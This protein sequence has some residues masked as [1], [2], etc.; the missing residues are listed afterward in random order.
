M[1]ND[2]LHKPG[3]NRTLYNVEMNGFPLSSHIIILTSPVCFA[4]T[5]FLS[6]TSIYLSVSTSDPGT[7]YETSDFMWH[8]ATESKTQLVSCKT[9]PKYLLGL[10]TLEDIRDIEA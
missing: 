10:S 7:K 9:S 2:Q 1:E 4:V 3:A 5:K 8:V 6:A